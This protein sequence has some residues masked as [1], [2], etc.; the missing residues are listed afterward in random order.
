MHRLDKLFTQVRKTNSVVKS[1]P[2]LSR[3]LSSEKSKDGGVEDIAK[4]SEETSVPVENVDNILTNLG[5]ETVQSEE[6]KVKLS[7]FAKAYER[8]TAPEEKEVEEPKTF[9][10][11]LRNSKL[12]DLGDP[13]GKVVR[14]KI[15]HI[16]DD[17]LH[18]DFGWKFNCVCKR[19]ARNGSDYVRGSIVRLKIKDLELSTRFLGSQKDL[20]ILE[21]D[22]TLLGLIWS[23]LRGKKPETQ[24]R[25][26]M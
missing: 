13:E 1:Y 8:Y 23:P 18:I 25:P 20:T 26:E 22:C 7:G 2:T 21:A 24:L 11:L 19:P 3:Y 16:I 12:I 4:K 14:G 5:L 10:N 17:D 9:A 6:E 15:L